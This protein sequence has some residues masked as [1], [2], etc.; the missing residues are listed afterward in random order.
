MEEI[1]NTNP[2]I[3]QT[4]KE[5]L[6]TSAEKRQTQAL[7]EKKKNWQE[8]ML[9]L[10]VGMLIAL[11]L[12]FFVATFVQMSYLHWSILNSPT[13]DL[14]STGEDALTTSVSTFEEF[15]Q[16]R[17]FEIRAAMERFIVEKRYHQASAYLMSGLWLRY[18]G[19]ITGMILALLG[20]SFILGKLREP[21]QKLEGAFSEISLSISTA[22]PGIILAVLGVALMFATLLDR[23]IYNVTDAN[24]Y[25]PIINPADASGISNNSL[26]PLPDLLGSE[27]P[28]TETVEGNLLSGEGQSPAPT[29][30]PKG[31]EP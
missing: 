7:V 18:L 11:T 25:L 24:T 28:T 27:N 23:D 6:L 19:F 2:E 31:G 12:F 26:P 16:A 8:R 20:A 13:I 5:N 10:M 14:D 17:Q 30:T 21:A 29:L 4:S 3:A 1:I 15:L 22:S 9:P